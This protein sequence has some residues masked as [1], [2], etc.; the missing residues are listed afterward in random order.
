[1][2][3][4]EITHKNIIIYSKKSTGLFPSTAP[5]T[6]RV[7]QFL[8]D[9]ENKRDVTKYASMPEKKYEPPRKPKEKP[10]FESY[11][12]MREEEEKKK[13]EQQQHVHT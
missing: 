4:F 7:R 6:D 10:T 12:K 9:L 8:D 3:A 1:M 11:K 13:R 5:T 2:G